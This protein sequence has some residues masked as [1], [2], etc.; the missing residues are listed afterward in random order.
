[1]RWFLSF[2]MLFVS[3][4]A[5]FAQDVD[6]A[7]AK[8][9]A[10]F[11]LAKIKRDALP[12]SDAKVKAAAGFKKRQEAR[13]PDCLS[14]LGVAIK[15]ADA[16][17]RP[18]FILIGMAC[19]DAPD[20]RK[21]FPDAVW[22]HVGDSFNGNSTPRLLVRPVGAATGIPFVR[23]DFGPG[24]QAEIRRVLYPTPGKGAAD[25][26]GWLPRADVYRRGRSSADC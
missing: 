18:L 13:D 11:A 24:T 16:E 19:H 26:E 15:R 3:V 2:V 5:C 8:A 10:A 9:K 14:D 20:I 22:V 4:F 21:G 7:T 25:S 1:M 6:V 17:K 23:K 12:A